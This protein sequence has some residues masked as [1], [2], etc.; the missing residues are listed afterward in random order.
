LLVSLL[1]PVVGLSAT[2][3]VPGV[4]IGVVGVSDVH[5]EHGPA[6][7][8]FPAVHGIVAVASVPTDPGIPILEVRRYKQNM[9]CTG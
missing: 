9:L 2:G 3:D 6:V 8:G 7:T 1:F 4:T 5:F